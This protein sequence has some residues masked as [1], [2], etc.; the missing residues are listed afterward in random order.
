MFRIANAT[1]A[2]KALRLSASLLLVLVCTNT[3]WAQ[4]T[5]FTYQG[6]LQDGGTPANGS[7]DLQFGLR[8]SN[9]GGTQIGSTQTVPTV[10]VSAGI[11]SVQLD[12]GANAFPGA[13][14][15]LEISARLNGV[16]SFTTLSPRQQITSTPYAIR[17]L[18][19]SSADAV[20]VNGVPGGS[21]NY[22]Q[23][24]TT[25]QAASNFNISG[26]GTAA[27]TLSANIVNATTQ[28]NI[29]GNRVLSTGFGNLFAGI[30]AG[31]SNMASDNSG[32]V[33]SFFGSN[34]GRDNT[35]GSGNSF[36][37]DGAGL[38]NQV[39]LRNSFFGNSAGQGF[40]AG[41]LA[42]I[43][44]DMLALARAD[45]GKQHLLKEDLY[46]NDLV[47][48]SCKA[49]QALATPKRIQLSCEAPEDLVFHGNEELLQRMSVNLIDNAI[50]Y[51][52]EGGSVSVKLAS[53]AACAQLVVSDTGIGIP[54]EA[55]GRVFDRFYRVGDVRTHANGGSGLDS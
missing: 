39:G 48:E 31:R 4:T 37:G 36:F 23:N 33:N 26:N 24:T 16:A 18:N 47:I 15:F 2:L 52:P 45:A 28:Y 49:A 9:G 14:R 12:F 1:S 30:N 8:D 40:S 44:S 13:N 21:G 50:R 54:R 38:R 34:A 17:S 7:Y 22:I 10:T 25:P 46:L 19:A 51:T 27:G 29:G 43:V 55:I 53:N 5:S 32:N 6:R 20:T 3:A 41:A 11:F 42:N 35:S